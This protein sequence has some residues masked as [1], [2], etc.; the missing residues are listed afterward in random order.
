[1]YLFNS[2]PKYVPGNPKNTDQ[3]EANGRWRDAKFSGRIPNITV[4]LGVNK[5]CINVPYTI[6]VLMTVLICSHYSD[7]GNICKNGVENYQ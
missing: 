2:A 6:L 7:S 4:L 1:M 5:V 3:N